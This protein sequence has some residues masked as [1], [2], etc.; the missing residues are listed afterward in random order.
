MKKIKLGMF[1]LL[2]MTTFV[3]VSLAVENDAEGF[4][5]WLWGTD[6]SS[7]GSMKLMTSSENGNSTYIKNNDNMKW[8]GVPVE[9]IRYGFKNGKLY[10]V[11]INI[12][13]LNQTQAN[14]LK[15]RL[16]EKYGN[17]AEIAGGRLLEWKGPKSIISFTYFD[18][19]VSNVSARGK[20][21]V[22]F[23]SVESIQSKIKK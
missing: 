4:R 18:S 14:N 13:G 19:S 21:I 9:K 23:E 1:L 6:V 8:E 16:K 5:E 7:M 22:R 17:A 11:T 2:F 10:L 3:A 20:A 15:S 12:K